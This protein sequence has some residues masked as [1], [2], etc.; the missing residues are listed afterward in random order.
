M[1]EVKKIDQKEKKIEVKKRESGV[2]LELLSKNR[3]FTLGAC[4]NN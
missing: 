1:I 3:N 2:N 4:C